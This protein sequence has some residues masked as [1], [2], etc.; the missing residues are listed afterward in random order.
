MHETDYPNNCQKIDNSLSNI[1]KSK[2]HI[3]AF[4]QQKE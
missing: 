1:F 3:R 2:Q 4:P